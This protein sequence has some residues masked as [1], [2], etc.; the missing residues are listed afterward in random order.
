MVF[1][2]FSRL[3]RENAFLLIVARF[4]KWIVQWKKVNKIENND[5]LCELTTKHKKVNIVNDFDE[6]IRKH[7]QGGKKVLLSV[8]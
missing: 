2:I 4:T 5:Y 6:K 3:K 8:K 7:Y 1:F